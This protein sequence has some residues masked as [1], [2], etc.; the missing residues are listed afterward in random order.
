MTN[1]RNGECEEVEAQVDLGLFNQRTFW[2]LWFLKTLS[3]KSNLRANNEKRA[4]RKVRHG[5]HRMEG[6]CPLGLSPVP[7][8]LLCC[9]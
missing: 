5:Q 3:E 4:R 1:I 2:G 9:I 8:F 6:V 7:T